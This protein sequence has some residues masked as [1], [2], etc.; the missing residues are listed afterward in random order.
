MKMHL[1]RYAE[2]C[3]EHGSAK[4]LQSHRFATG[5]LSTDHQRGMPAFS[6]NGA[7]ARTATDETATAETTGVAATCVGAAFVDNI[8]RF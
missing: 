3:H 4:V 6:V 1:Q 5:I 2:P 7:A 8:T